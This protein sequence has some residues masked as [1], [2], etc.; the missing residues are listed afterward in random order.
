VKRGLLKELANTPTKMVCGYRLYG[1]DLPRLRDLTGE[2]VVIDLIGGGCS[3]AEIALVPPLGIAT[4]LQ[5]WLA[6]TLRREDV[7]PDLLSRAH[8]T[9]TPHLQPS[10]RL[11]VA[12]K[13]V[14]ETA[15]GNYQSEETAPWHQGDIADVESA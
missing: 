10:G 1:P 7:P 3:V 9:L 13:T 2:S 14:I 11:D 8:T 6:Q 15:R 12:C 5:D 4:D